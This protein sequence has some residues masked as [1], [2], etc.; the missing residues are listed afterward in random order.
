VWTQVGKVAPGAVRHSPK[1]HKSSST[2]SRSLRQQPSIAVWRQRPVAVSHVSSV[3]MS[4]SSWRQ[5][6]QAFPPVPQASISP[7]SRHWFAWQQPFGQLTPSQTQVPFR[8]RMLTGHCRQSS[9]PVPQ[10]P[11]VSPARQNPN[12]SQ[13]PSAQLPAWH[14]VQT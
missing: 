2:Q 12:S 11:S 8:Q 7:P 14:G 13:Q 6:L 5:S 4:L 3:Q 1:E 10:S 9:P